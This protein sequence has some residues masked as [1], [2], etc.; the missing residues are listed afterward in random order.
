[1][2]IVHWNCS[3]Q[4]LTMLCISTE[5]LIQHFKITSTHRVERQKITSRV[6]LGSL[7][8]PRRGLFT[9]PP[10]HT[11]QI[12]RSSRPNFIWYAIPTFST[13]FLYLGW[14]S[15]IPRR[16]SPATKGTPQN[17]E[18]RNQ[19]VGFGIQV[20]YEKG[21]RSVH[22]WYTN[23]GPYELATDEIHHYTPTTWDFE[24]SSR[25]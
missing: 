7:C 19:P 15:T 12:D 24:T 2:M 4:L 11:I 10:T 6:K 22:A 20:N 18:R 16:T 25:Y 9:K 21:D 1:M 17:F 8:Q 23:L 13:R 5:I 14:K 3:I